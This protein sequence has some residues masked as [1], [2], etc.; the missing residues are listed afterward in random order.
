MLPYRSKDKEVTLMLL[1]DMYKQGISPYQYALKNNTIMAD[2][3]WGNVIDR[4]T[5]I[6]P[7]ERYSIDQLMNMDEFL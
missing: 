7:K 5:R 2:E 1:F 6:D 3:Y 4:C